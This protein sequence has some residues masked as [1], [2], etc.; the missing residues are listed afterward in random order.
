MSDFVNPVGSQLPSKEDYMDLR[1]ELGDTKKEP[2]SDQVQLEATILAGDTKQLLPTMLAK[3]ISEAK[4]MIHLDLQYRMAPSVAPFPQHHIYS[5]RLK[6]HPDAET[7]NGIRRMVR[8]VAE[9]RGIKTGQ[10]SE[11]CPGSVA[12]VRRF[13][14]SLQNHANVDTINELVRDLV[15]EGI[16]PKDISILCFYKAET[17]LIVYRMV[18][19]SEDECLFEEVSTADAYQG[20]EAPVIIVD[21]VIAE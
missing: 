1:D 2:A 10:G 5:G 9:K 20:R 18:V 15:A 3:Q 21:F 6:T 13:G 8:A 4:E 11:Y 14:T 16:D 19:C 7:D 17:R 12:R